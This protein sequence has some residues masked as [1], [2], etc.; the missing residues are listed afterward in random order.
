MGRPKGEIDLNSQSCLE[1]AFFRGDNE[2]AWAGQK[3]RELRFVIEDELTQVYVAIEALGDCPL[4]VQGWHHK[5][6]PASM[7]VMQIM[8]AVFGGKDSPVLWPLNAPEK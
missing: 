7:N 8:E 1:A 5:T 3:Y 6:F 4:N 2:M